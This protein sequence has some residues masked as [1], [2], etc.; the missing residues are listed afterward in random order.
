MK[1][2]SAYSH[3]G[4]FGGEVSASQ[5]QFKAN[6]GESGFYAGW[7]KNG[8]MFVIYSPALGIECPEE[9]KQS[10][11]HQGTTEPKDQLKIMY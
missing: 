5:M 6:A 9:F 1:S 10:I 8:P 7:T 3:A 4:P 11:V 2:L